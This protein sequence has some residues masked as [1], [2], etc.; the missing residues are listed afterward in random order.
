MR[1]YAKKKNGDEELWGVGGEA[2]L[3]ESLVLTAS[4]KG[5]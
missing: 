1:A 5:L 4:L 3:E 2:E